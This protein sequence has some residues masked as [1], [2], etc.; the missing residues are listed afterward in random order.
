MLQVTILK[1]ARI[2]YTWLRHCSSSY[3]LSLFSIDYEIFGSKKYAHVLFVIYL[4]VH[5]IVYLFYSQPRR[6]NYLNMNLS[7]QSLYFAQKYTQSI[8]IINNQ[9][10]KVI[11]TIF[12][13]NPLFPTS[14]EMYSSGWVPLILDRDLIS[15]FAVGI[16][17]ITTSLYADYSKHTR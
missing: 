3:Q 7:R 15:D 13:C 5:F 8:S 14:Y 12:T 1:V 11:T 6:L 2:H 17:E 4:R 10:D 9:L 16:Q